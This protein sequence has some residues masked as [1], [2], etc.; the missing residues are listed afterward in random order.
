M[1]TILLVDDDVDL[2]EMNKTVLTQLGYQV[3]CAYS[4]QEAGKIVDESPV[5]IAVV[6]VMMESVS[7]GFDL[8]RDMHRKHPKLP[9]LVLTG[10]REAMD[11]QFEF[12][13]DKNWL[14][15][16]KIL[17]KPLAQADLAKE[18]NAILRGK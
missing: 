8:V 12:K 10:V 15:V 3:K 6:D 14:P 1:T 9:M 5:D 13:P 2:V 17:E 18:I 4:T 16:V 7:A 11:L